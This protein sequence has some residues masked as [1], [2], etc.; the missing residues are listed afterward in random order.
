MKGCRLRCQELLSNVVRSYT[1][2]NV[3]FSRLRRF[4]LS[5]LGPYRCILLL[6]D[7]G[8]ERESLA[9]HMPDIREDVELCASLGESQCITFSNANFRKA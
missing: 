1:P 5:R 8:A 6:V 3:D 4:S 9:R 2:S 7:A